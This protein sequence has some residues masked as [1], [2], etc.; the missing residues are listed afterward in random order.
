[1]VVDG[2]QN[3]LRV[4]ASGAYGPD[5]M[6][7][8]A[9]ELGILLWSEFEFGDALYPVDSEFLA[10]V[11]E[12]ASYQVRR[13]NH[14]PS[15]ALWAGGNELE[16]LELS[17]VNSSAPDQL[18]R[19]TGEYELL[20]LNTILPCVYGN[21]KSI[22]YTPSSTS[23]GWLELN[24][25]NP[26]PMVE[27]YQNLTPGY[28][29][30]D[31]DFYHYDSSDVF[32]FS[33][34]PVGRFANEFGYHSYPSLQTWQQVLPKNQFHFNSSVVLGRNR[35][36][37]PGNLDIIN[38]TNSL[39]GA[40][41]ITMA[42]ERYYPTPNMSDS[43]A[44]FS[45]WCQTTQIFQ[46]DLYRS[47]IQFYRRGSG[48][49]ERQLGSLYW[50]L[51]DLWQAP[52]WAGIE[53][54]GRWKYLHYAAKDI[55][56]PIII[57]P[58][59]N[60]TTGDFE[61][62]V[63]SDLWS[64]ATGMASLAWYTWDGTPIQYS[65]SK[66]RP[67]AS[68]SIPFTV[69]AINTTMVYSTNLLQ[70]GL[71]LTNTALFMNITATGNPINSDTTTTY[72]HSNFFHPVPLSQAALVDPGLTMT[73][74]EATKKFTVEATSGIAAWTWLD[75]PAG[76][77]VSFDSN[78]FALAPGQPKEIGYTVRSD[79]EESKWISG[80]TVRSVWNNTLS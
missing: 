12:E 24:F 9:D 57:S 11:A 69:G 45:A 26:I 31:T 15:L 10:N 72:Q 38:R 59:Y 16:S 68:S 1:M 79:W 27:R 52:T 62:Y 49:K 74:D 35:H 5:F 54:D 75:Y 65:D 14:H 29:Y 2:N 73:Y 41:Q 67:N 6:Y 4:W 53:Y 20:F 70:S 58:F 71:N 32:N 39:V 66:T 36:N 22:S 8:I 48:F 34:Y 7:D 60:Y 25:S 42:V 3:M 44:N 47:E 51:E 40:G 28:I 19:Y 46:A 56:E 63:T 43:I 77:V 17:N 64:P 55:Y 37:P 18:A 61:I 33:L 78:A 23:N 13:L 76:G 80:V 21:S 30:G 50:Q